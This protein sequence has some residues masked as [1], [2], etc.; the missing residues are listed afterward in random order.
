MSINTAI[1]DRTHDSDQIGSGSLWQFGHGCCPGYS[2][3]IATVIRRRG[4][5]GTSSAFCLELGLSS[6]WMLKSYYPHPA[7]SPQS[8]LSSLL[9]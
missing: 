6:N 5:V 8:C 4:E 3:F 1:S 9:I 2:Q 7:I